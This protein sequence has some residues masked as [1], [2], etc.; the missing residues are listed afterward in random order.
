[1]MALETF[2]FERLMHP[3]LIWLWAA[4]AALF[5]A[6]V[7]A[8][9]PGLMRVSTGETLAR[10]RGRGAGWF[11]Y[12]P[13]A[14]RALGLGLLVVALARP[15]KDLEPRRDTADVIDI[16]LCVDVSGSMQAMDFVEGGERRD[17]LSVTKEAVRD[18]LRNRTEHDEDRFGVDRIGLVV[19][20]GYAWTQCPLTLDY[21]MLERELERAHID[22]TDPKK[23][24]TAIGSAL[25][26]AVGKLGKS[27]AESKVI[28]LL[29]DGRHN[30]GELDPLTAALFAK[31]FGIRV[32]TIG[33]GSGGQ[34]LV[35]R[36]GLLG[37]T[38]VPMNLPIDIETLVQIAETTGGR[39]YRA[40]DTASLQGAYREIDQLETTEIEI[41]DAVDYKEGFVPWAALGTASLLASVFS[42]RLWF[43]AI[44]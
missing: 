4:V 14:I 7:S 10:I 22:E 16:M 35:R 43:E 42:R 28:V 17:R 6:E 29:T 11:R 13:A 5:L 12:L 27:E 21:G 31:D 23:Q 30:R 36:K 15:M 3:G 33:A 38:M 8:R 9:A 32:Y 41:T 37:D 19:Y 34:A 1:M 25:G 18:F 26:L 2:R 40:T 20:A 44:P 24:G 39:F